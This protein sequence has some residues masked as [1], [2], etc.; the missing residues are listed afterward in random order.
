VA[1][2][3]VAAEFAAANGDETVATYLLETADAWNASIERW[4]TGR[5]STGERGFRLSPYLS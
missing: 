3:V 1:A 4:L 2:L 5:A